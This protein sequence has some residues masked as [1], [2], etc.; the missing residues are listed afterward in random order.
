MSVKR[1]RLHIEN[2][3]G[4]GLIL[5]LMTLLVL[6]VLGASLGA[7]TVGSFKLS[8]ANRDDTSAYYIAEAGANM[9]YEEMK[10][11]VLSEYE[12]DYSEGVFFDRVTDDNG[13]I[14]NVEDKIK[15]NKNGSGGPFYTF[16][17]Q[18]GSIPSLTIAIEEITKDGNKRGYM[19]SSTGNVDGKKRTVKKPVEVTYV[20]ED[21]E[22]FPDNA[23]IIASGEIKLKKGSKIDGDV[24]VSNVSN[25][26]VPG[27]STEPED[28]VSGSIVSPIPNWKIYKDLARSFPEI[29]Q[30]VELPNTVNLDKNEDLYYRTDK[31]NLSDLT[32]N[33]DGVVNI[34]VENELTIDKKTDFDYSTDFR[35]V[36]IYYAGTD[37]VKINS[38]I[39]ASL[40]IKNAPITFANKA[41]LEGILVSGNEGS[42]IKL[43]QHGDF[44]ETYIIAPFSNVRMNNKSNYNGFLIAG[45][46]NNVNKIDL[47]Y[48]E[49]NSFPFEIDGIGQGMDGSEGEVI[50]SEPIIESD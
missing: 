5:A 18:N 2:E 13:V 42:E 30:Y 8:D 47:N 27:N 11:G 23:A 39:K 41:S 46:I 48:K 1:L 32:I 37:T 49:I 50:T 40:F 21:V 19:I 22:L 43:S 17:S 29:G 24:I 3:E 28:S 36:R 35:N 26:T 12:N 34:F 10:E 33:G 14:K 31:L 25:L 6:S 9:A 44:S 7:V 20:R 16:E 38:K 45:N 15:N 4:S